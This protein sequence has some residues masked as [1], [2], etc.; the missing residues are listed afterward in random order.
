M[1]SQPG[2]KRNYKQEMKTATS[3]GEDKHRAMRNAARAEAIR[4]GKVKKGDGK[5]I[6]HKKPLR[7]GGTNTPSNLRVR[8]ASANKADNGHSKKK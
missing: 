7:S 4:A 5:E 6:D 2:Y 8:S 1:P 3:R